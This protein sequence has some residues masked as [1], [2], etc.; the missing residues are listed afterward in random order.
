MIS[1]DGEWGE[2]GKG[3]KFDQIAD[4]KDG[5]V[6]PENRQTGESG[7][8]RMGKRKRGATLQIQLWQLCIFY[9]IDL[10]FDPLQAGWR[11]GGRT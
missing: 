11:R 5:R 4:E 9:Y 3:K 6:L 1:V 7:N 8:R 2:G 10:T